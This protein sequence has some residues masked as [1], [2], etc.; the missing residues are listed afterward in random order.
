MSAHDTLFGWYLVAV[1]SLVIIVGLAAIAIDEVTRW[2]ERRRWE[3]PTV[4]RA[5]SKH[6]R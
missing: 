2:K 5:R 4:R 1:L 3:G 6:R